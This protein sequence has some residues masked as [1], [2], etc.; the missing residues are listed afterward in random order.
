MVAGLNVKMECSSASAKAI[1][2][3]GGS[4]GF[5]VHQK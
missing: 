3:V 5:D 2:H 4:V 1:E